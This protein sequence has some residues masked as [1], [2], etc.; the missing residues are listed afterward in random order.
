M[1]CTISQFNGLIK[2]NYHDGRNKK[3]CHFPD[4][5]GMTIANTGMKPDAGK[6]S[7]TLL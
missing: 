4:G 3:D 7:Q 1:D 6:R 2:Q 5:S